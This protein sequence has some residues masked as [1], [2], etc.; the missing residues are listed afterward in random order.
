MS[1]ERGLIKTEF[2]KVEI[3][4]FLKEVHLSISDN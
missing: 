2:N 3:N 4:V 1:N